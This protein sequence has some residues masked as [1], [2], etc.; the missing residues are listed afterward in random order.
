MLA[1]NGRYRPLI[2]TCFS[3]PDKVTLCKKVLAASGAAY[4]KKARPG[5]R[6]T[7]FELQQWTCDPADPE[8]GTL[9]ARVILEIPGEPKRSTRAR[10]VDG[11]LAQG[12]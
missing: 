12:I 5:E 10:Q 11:A 3:T 6:L 2:R 9:A 8:H 1:L 7:R 4:N